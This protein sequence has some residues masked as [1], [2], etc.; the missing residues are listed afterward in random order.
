MRRGGAASGGGVRV[1]AFHRLRGGVVH[2]CNTSIQPNF[3][4]RGL[5]AFAKGN[6]SCSNQLARGC[7]NVYDDE[8]HK[9]QLLQLLGITLFLTTVFFGRDLMTEFNREVGVAQQLWESFISSI[10]EPDEATVLGA[11][12]STELYPVTQVVDGDTLKVQLG[13]KKETVRV[14]GI[15]TPET[16]D[17]RKSVECFGKEASNRAKELL[18][19]QTVRLESDSTQSDRDRYGRLLR[20]VFL[21]NGDDVGKQLIEE[22]F[23]QESL[24]SNTPHKY[25]QSY[26]EAQE[27]AQAE[28]RG[29][30]AEE[31]CPME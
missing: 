7:L 18:M 5:V 6:I 26:L 10:D 17:P 12:T 14:V 11:S 20:F 4:L 9:R 24:Y 31:S 3:F 16:V 30:W 1:G 8:V 2:L 21:A 19:G 27:R 15:N 25:R 29:L 13:D 23:A 28:K 22:G